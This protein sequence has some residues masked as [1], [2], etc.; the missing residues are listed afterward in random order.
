MLKLQNVNFSYPNTHGALRYHG[1]ISGIDF[2]L[3]PGQTMAVVGCTGAGKTTL[4]RLIAGY[5]RPDSGQ[6]EW[7]GKPVTGPSPDRGVVFQQNAMFPWLTVAENVEFGLKMQKVPLATRKKKVSEYLDLLNLGRF[8]AA[9]LFKIQAYDVMLRVSLARCLVLEPQLLILDDEP[10]GELDDVQRTRL[11]KLLLNIWQSKGFMMLTT[12]HDVDE[13]L[14]LST[15]I[16]IMGGRPGRI[17]DRFKTSFAPRA[18]QEGIKAI[19]RS[20][21]FSEIRQ[22]ILH[23]IVCEV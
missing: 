1:D 8:A 12:T 5:M 10:L 21:E 20:A 22:S 2:E 4:V 19:R 23:H 13:A 17:V 16:L 11:Q 15:D 3:K 18:V 7:Q 9:S 14:V 6:I